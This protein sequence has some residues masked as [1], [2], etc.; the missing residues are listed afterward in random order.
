MGGSLH[1]VITTFPLRS[2]LPVLAPPLPPIPAGG[3]EGHGGI[4]CAHRDRLPLRPD[5]LGFLLDA[6]DFPRARHAR[7]IA[8][9]S[10]EHGLT[11]I[12]A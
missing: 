7:V 8:I 12:L 3:R 1:L 10:A 2:L 4:S 5:G 6:R 9:R 11:L